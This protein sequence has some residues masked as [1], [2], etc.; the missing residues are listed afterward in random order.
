MQENLI[1]GARWCLNNKELIAGIA[2]GVVTISSVIVKVTPDKTDNVVLEKILG[3]FDFLSISNLDRKAIQV[4]EEK[5][6]KLEK[7][8]I[9]I[10]KEQ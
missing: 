7:E 9:D 4:L 6:N 3:F 5:V 2:S 10:K 1:N 8:K